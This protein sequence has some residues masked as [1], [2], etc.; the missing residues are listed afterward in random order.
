MHQFQGNAV[1]PAIMR[2]VQAKQNINVYLKRL[3]RRGTSSKKDL[4]SISLAVAPQDMS[5][6][7]K[8]QRRAWEMCTEIPLKK[9]VRR[10]SHL[11]FSK[12]KN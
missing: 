8:W 4:F 11:K 3:M 12:T 2:P 9:T 6:S 5:I 10:K 1:A 7:K